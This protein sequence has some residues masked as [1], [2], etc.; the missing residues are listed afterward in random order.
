LVLANPPFGD[1]ASGAFLNAAAIKGNIV[2]VERGVES[3]QTM[4]NEA[5]AAG[6]TAL[7]ILDK[8]ADAGNPPIVAGGTATT[9]PVVMLGNDDGV[10]LSNALVAGGVT[11]SIGDDAN[12]RLGEANFG[13]GNS[14]VIFTVFAPAAGDYP[15]LINYFQGGGGINAEFSQIVNG[16][17]GGNHVLVNDVANGGLAAFSHL[18]P[19]ATPISVSAPLKFSEPTKAGGNVT[20]TWTGNGTL[21]QATALTG[22]A[23]DWSNVPGVSGNSY[24]ITGATGKAFFRLKQ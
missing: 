5:V 20:I 22:S 7:V 4:A 19:G 3:F 11:A 2:A 24:T 18:K 12:L 13:K 9:I 15:F 1:D 23:S 16:H 17:L 14:D 21:Q 6:A 10:V 8:D